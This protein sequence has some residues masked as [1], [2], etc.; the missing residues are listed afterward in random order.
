MF[1]I[2]RIHTKKHIDRFFDF[3]IDNE[4]SNY[5]EKV[6]KYRDIAVNVEI[7]AICDENPLQD[8]KV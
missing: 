8:S 4:D 5:F 3:C 6:K 7:I 2:F 1:I